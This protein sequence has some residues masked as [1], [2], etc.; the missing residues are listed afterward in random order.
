MMLRW[1]TLRQEKARTHSRGA[2]KRPGDKGQVSIFVLLVLGLFLLGFVGFAVDMTNLWFHRQTA[3]GAADA[4]CQAGIMDVL[5]S[6]EGIPTTGAGF[7]PGTA[8]DCAASS[9]AAPCRYAALNGYNGTGLVV[10]AE[11]N[12]VAVSFPT[13]VS[14]PLPPS[15]QPPNSLAPVP[16]LQADVTDRVRLTFASLISGNRTSDVRARAVCALALARQ[17]IPL[18]VLNPTCSHSFDIQD[19]A[20]TLKITG[21]PNKSVQVNSNS[22]YTPGVI[23]CAAATQGSS[24]GCAGNGTIDLSQGG[25]A[26]TGSVFGTFGGESPAPPNFLPGTTGAWSSPSSPISD[27]FAQMA[28]PAVPL[29]PVPPSWFP[30]AC[31]TPPTVPCPVTY[32][33]NGCPDHTTPCL[34]YTP[35]LYTSPIIVKGVTAIFDPGVYYI[36]PTSYTGAQSG[37][38][39]GKAACADVGSIGGQCR[40]DFLVDSNGV[41]RQSAGPAVG[42]GTNGTVFYLSSGIP[43]TGYGSVFF[44]ANAGNYGARFIDDYVTAGSATSTPAICPGGPIPNPPLPATAAGNVLLGPC[45]GPFGDPLGLERRMLLFQDRANKD[46]SGQAHLGGSGGFLLAGTMYFHNCPASPTCQPY[47][48]DYNAFLQFQGTPGSTTR[49][50]GEIIADQ[51]AIAGNGSIN[52]VLDPNA[53]FNILKATLLQ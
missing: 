32:G 6:A 15:M 53:V 48:T 11:S 29:P 34:E 19:T 23:N 41:V 9:T 28:P 5:L 21:G 8:F 17:P 43:A 44:G 10:N 20:A 49:V 42:N 51:L 1:I 25:P 36:A 37:Q 47:N 35:G 40:A 38:L 39:C 45:S 26:L 46:L 18:I 12:D 52:M 22:T 13:T 27:P 16:Y 30:A 2:S 7:T 31:Q 33:V 4:A 3:Q 50:I 14:N 24:T